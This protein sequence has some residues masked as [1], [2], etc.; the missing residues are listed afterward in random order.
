[1]STVSTSSSSSSVGSTRN[2]QKPEVFHHT[3]RC[4]WFRLPAPPSA[5]TGTLRS[6]WLVTSSSWRCCC[7]SNL[8]DESDSIF[9]CLVSL[10]P[11]LQ[12]G[13]CCKSPLLFRF[14]TH[15]YISIN[16]NVSVL[17][18]TSY[19]LTVAN[20][21]MYGLP[22]THQTLLPFFTSCIGFLFIVW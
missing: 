7:Y 12:S 10:H 19:Y 18:P 1:M 15:E 22:H 9:L 20:P 21:T 4:C 16:C 13:V 3:H 17:H 5:A 11:P 6:L 8:R 14:R 2:G